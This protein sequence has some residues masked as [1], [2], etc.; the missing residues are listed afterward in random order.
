MRGL[1]AVGGYV[2]RHHVALV[3]LVV[4]LGGTAYAATKLPPKSV[5]TKQLKTGAV[6]AK[7]I[8]GGAVGSDA[9]LDNSIGGAD[10]EES[11]LQ[12]INAT[13]LEGQSI[14]GLSSI[15]RST[16]PPE[17][18]CTDDQHIS[19]G[20]VCGSIAINV[21]RT[22][23]LLVMISG[24][25]SA[26]ALDDDT[27]PGSGTD[28][29]TAVL[30]GCSAL[31]DGDIATTAST[32]LRTAGASDSISGAAVTDPV[33]AGAHTLAVSCRE[34]DGDADFGDVRAS[35]ITLSAD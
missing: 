34:L 2:R 33:A 21:P 3:A 9:V 15:G 32:L 7:K 18:G 4:A 22:A 13:T 24:N 16:P 17:P 14:S 10:I 12:G 11:T 23:R 29:P 19:G 30:G 8:A 1:S 28:G 31:V 6:T 26:T 25:V 27:G 20:Q 5:G 35:A